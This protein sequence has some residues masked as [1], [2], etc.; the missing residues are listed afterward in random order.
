MVP[1]VLLC[2][3]RRTQRPNSVFVQ[4][5]D[6]NLRHGAVAHLYKPVASTHRGQVWAT[7]QALKEAAHGH[8]ADALPT[9]PWPARRPYF[10]FRMF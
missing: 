5:L 3:E 2:K 6:E 10:V 4:S 9:P 7:S 8:L 1:P